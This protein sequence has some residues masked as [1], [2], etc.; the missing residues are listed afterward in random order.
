MSSTFSED[1]LESSWQHKIANPP[2]VG[3]CNILTDVTD[4]RKVDDTISQIADKNGRLDGL[5]AAAGVQRIGQ[6]IGQSQEAVEQVMRTNFFGA[7]NC[8]TACGSQRLERKCLGSIVLVASMSGLVANKGMYCSVYNSSKAAVIHLARNL[9]QEWGPNNDQGSGGI[10]VNSVC[11]GH[12]YTPM[13]EKTF[14][15]APETK[16]IWAHENMLQKI[17]RPWEF[18]GVSLFLMSDASSFMTGNA[19]ILD[20][21]HTAW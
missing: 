2:L 9:A 14:K 8:A 16:V 3:S 5:I 6:A 11:P 17:A 18:K 19:L 10:R 21:S 4:V 15:D 1:Q 13:V 12:T 20:G 7:F